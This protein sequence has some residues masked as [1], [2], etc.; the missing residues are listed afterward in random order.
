MKSWKWKVGAGVFATAA[1]SGSFGFGFARWRIDKQ[2]RDA[3]VEHHKIAIQQPE[4]QLQKLMPAKFGVPG[5][6]RTEAFF[7]NFIWSG[8][9]MKAILF[10]FLGNGRKF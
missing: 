5:K 6:T 8:I 9:L 10:F 2:L 1:V 3:E 7:L 4:I